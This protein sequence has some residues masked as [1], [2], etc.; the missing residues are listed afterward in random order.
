[1]SEPTVERFMSPSPH[2]IGDD[3]PLSAAHELM[4]KYDI[5]HLPVLH[6]GKLV[7]MLSQR[8]LH[9]IETLTD[10]DQETVAV[11]E[12]MTVDTYAV[13]LRGTLRKVAA[14]MADHRYGSAVIIDK[15]KVIG[16]ITTV[17]CLRALSA[18]LDE[19]RKPASRDA[20]QQP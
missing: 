7:G 15:D 13:G 9:F 4:R 12:A 1:M 17:D 16:I 5:R 3:Q 11:S 10:V 18:L 14:E 6:G 8:D 19:Q 20:A 2:T